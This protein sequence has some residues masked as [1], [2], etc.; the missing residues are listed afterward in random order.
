MT[1]QIYVPYTIDDLH[2]SIND[3]YEQYDSGK[4]SN[5]EAHNILNKCCLH[6]S[7]GLDGRWEIRHRSEML[8]GDDTIC[9]W[10]TEQFYVLDGRTDVIGK[11]N[12]IEEALSETK[13]YYPHKF[14]GD[15]E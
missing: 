11:G 10:A 5:E 4:I 13:K 12:T 7:S 1:R 14:N 3:I 2:S 6:F 8:E 15:S 9:K